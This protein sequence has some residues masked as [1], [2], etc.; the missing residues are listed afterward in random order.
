MRALV[1]TLA[2]I[3]FALLCAPQPLS[4]HGGLK[5]SVPARDAHLETAPRDIVLTF[6][7]PS[8]L[9]VTRIRLVGADSTAVELGPLAHIDG[10][11]LKVVRAAILGRMAKGAYVV[12]WQTAGADGHPVRGS[13][14]FM[15]MNDPPPVPAATAGG[16]GATGAATGSMQGAELA[17]RSDEF[18]AESPAYVVIRWVTFMALVALLGVVSFKYLVIE[19]LSAGADAADLQPCG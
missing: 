4:A 6:T 1:R 7:E 15:V 12:E 11:T 8:P 13:F 5:S 10:D 16:T 2:F 18:D 14:T 9:A 19:R 17:Q 3:A